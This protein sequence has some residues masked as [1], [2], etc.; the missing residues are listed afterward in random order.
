MQPLWSICLQGSCLISSSSLNPSMQIG[1]TFELF[2]M[3]RVLI[4]EVL[5]KWTSSVYIKQ[6]NKPIYAMRD[7]LY[8]LLTIIIL[9]YIRHP[10]FSILYD[11]FWPSC[12]LTFYFAITF[13]ILVS[14]M[15][16]RLYNFQVGITNVQ[17]SLSG[18]IKPL[19]SPGPISSRLTSHLQTF[20]VIETDQ[21]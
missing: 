12:R 5:L 8:P 15:K 21:S 20:L 7:Q 14:L 9:S 10:F 17:K 4:L 13:K 3:I 16:L 2:F 19:S 6:G 11:Q 1:Q 18:P